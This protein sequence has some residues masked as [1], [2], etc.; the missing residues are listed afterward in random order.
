MIFSFRLLT[1]IQTQICTFYRHTASFKIWI[2][3]VQDFWNFE[4]WPIGS[5][6]SIIGTFEAE[7]DDEKPIYGLVH[8]LESWNPLWSQVSSIAQDKHKNWA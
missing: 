4:L 7:K 6:Y 5:L 3:K 1:M 2:S 8:N